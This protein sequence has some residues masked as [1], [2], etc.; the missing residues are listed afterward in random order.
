MLRLAD[1]SAALPAPARQRS[2]G[3]IALSVAR[4]GAGTRVSRIGE[5]GPLRVRL[6]RSPGAALEAV[7]VNTGGGIACG[8]SFAIDIEAGAGSELV[9]STTAAEKIYRSDGPEATIAVRL[10]LGAGAKLD[11][12]PQETILFDRARLRRRFDADLAA[13]ARL[14]C[15][16]AIVFG[17]GA[18]GERVDEGLIEDRWRIRRDRKLI[19]ADTLRLDGPMAGLLDRAAIGGG[20]R[21]LATFLHAAPDAEARLEEAR[22]YL[23]GAPCPCGASA[24]RGV[25]AVRFLAASIDPLRRAA[26][27]FI[28]RFRGTPMPRVWQT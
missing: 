2:Q 4:F 14:S 25:L 23:S 13:D 6:P 8:D 9:V 15:F 21:A 16:E 5:G 7:L 18:S 28:T 11:W 19:F 27:T 1:A 26:A 3:R 24:W 17:R 22:E 10:A 12:L 20:A